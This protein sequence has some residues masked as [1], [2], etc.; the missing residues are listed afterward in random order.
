MP[1]SSN[2]TTMQTIKEIALALII[3]VVGYSFAILLLSL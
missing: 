1:T 2:F 3:L